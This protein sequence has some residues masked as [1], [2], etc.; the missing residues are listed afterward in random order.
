MFIRAHKYTV[1]NAVRF[2]EL[3]IDSVQTSCGFAVPLYEMTGERDTLAKWAEN[4]GD[5]GIKEYWADRNRVSIDGKPT[6]IIEE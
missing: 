3:H 5:D 1:Q 4:K 6:H 2:F